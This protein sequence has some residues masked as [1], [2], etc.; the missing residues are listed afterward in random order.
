[1]YIVADIL[2]M[3]HTHI[4]IIIIDI[5]TSNLSLD[6]CSESEVNFTCIVTE[7]TTLQWDVTDF[8]I[9][10]NDHINRV[11]FFSTDSIGR[12]LY[13]FI[14]G[15]GAVYNFRLISTSP[16]TSTMTTNM[17]TD[18]SGATVSCSNGLQSSADVAT[19]ALHGK[20]RNISM[21]KPMVDLII[22]N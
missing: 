3:Y 13:I 12:E 19:L 7:S 11:Q 5:G 2:L 18:L 14:Q 21:R 15:T 16:L 6:A 10:S 20:Y 8:T 17:L 22:F 9:L 4:I 1:M